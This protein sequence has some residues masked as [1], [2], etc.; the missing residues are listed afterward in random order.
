MQEMKPWIRWLVPFGSV[1]AAALFILAMRPMMSGVAPFYPYVV[2]LAL[3]AYVAGA[4]PAFVALAASFAVILG[5]LPPSP[6]FSA[7]SPSV[8]AFLA[9]YFVGSLVMIAL[10][11]HARRGLLATR[12]LA[13]ELKASET[14]L[15]RAADVAALNARVT[16][17]TRS[18]VDPNAIALA[19]LEA[20]RAYLGAD[21]CAYAEVE[22]DED[23]FAFAGCACAAGVPAVTGR[24]PVSAFGTEALRLL[25]ARQPFVLADSADLPPGAERDAYRA[26]GIVAMIAAPLHR[27]ERFVAGTG[28]HMQ[29]ARRWT[30]EEVA[31]VQSITERIWEAVERARAETRLSRVEE[32][33]RAAQ[34]SSIVPFT[35]LAAV[36]DGAG[37]I[38][39]FA[40]MYVNPAAS[41]VLRR[42]AGDLMGRRLLEV[43]PGNRGLLFDSYVRVVESGEPMRQEIPYAADGIEGAF[44]NVCSRLDDGVAVWFLDVSEQRRSTDEIARQ[45][46][47][48]RT[49][50][51]LLPVGVAISHDARGDHISASRRFA[52]LLG[53]AETDN[54]SCTGPNRDVVTFRFERDGRELAADELPM[55]VASRTGQEIRD[56]EFDAV[57]A[58][59]RVHHLMVSAAP[60]FGPDGKVRGSIGTHVDVTSLKRIQQE[61]LLADRQKNEFLATL[62]HE[63]RNPMAPIRYAAALIRPDATPE[64]LDQARRTL[65]RQSAQ[66]ARLLDDLLD[67]SRITRNVIELQRG[68]CDLREIAA[69]AIDA[70]RPELVARHHR[71]VTSMPPAPLW[72]DGD[73]ARLLQV[74]GNLLGNAVKYTPLGGRIEVALD[75]IDGR[76]RVRVVDSGVGLSPDMLPRVF[77]LFAQVH[78]NLPASQGGL[79][80]GLAVVKRLVELHGG[81]VAAASAGLGQGACFSIELP[82]VAAPAAILAAADTPVAPLPG[83]SP[84]VL[85]VDDNEDAANLLAAVF[86]GQGWPVQVA[87]RGRQALALADA[88]RPDVVV[89]DIGL[90]DL[91]GDLVAAELRQRPGGAGM[92]LVAVTGWGQAEDRQR[93]REAGFDLHCVKPVDAQ[94]LVGVV[95]RRQ[96]S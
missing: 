17:A 81:R 50:L 64:Q 76:A 19:A 38:V 32:R 44:L 69:E 14:R 26:T 25:R 83:R 67:V 35:I 28:V 12:R 36:R 75:E 84:C 49:M 55:Q 42:P 90:P 3:T 31:I 89:L 92:L 37:S 74:I 8:Q 16:D 68:T 45:R 78:K 59:G 2:A 87:Y 71:L 93:T 39:D 40:W 82:Q 61:L 80:I 15:R 77:G 34:D 41:A 48:L 57:S 56:V 96:L 53:L 94:E 22:S 58:D 85:V 29:V 72:V 46:E 65:E 60:L 6:V 47:E 86:R 30:P 24:F 54:V 79:G 43:L 73:A 51:D 27:G 5:L 21:R 88:L 23:H 10:V 63:L 20:L 33:F 91:A 9:S 70:A 95:R 7:T 4:G 62:A 1:G 66:M 13:D 18:L 52:D 11:L